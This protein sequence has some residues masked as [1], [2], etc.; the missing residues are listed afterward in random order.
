MKWVVLAAT[1][2]RGAEV[3]DS[4]GITAENATVVTTVESTLGLE[5]AAGDLV[6]VDNPGFWEV[7]DWPY[8]MQ[9]VRT[10]NALAG[11]NWVPRFT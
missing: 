1:P 5:M 3:A 4:T 2:E 10:V 9:N 6:L 11:N 7:S 8:I